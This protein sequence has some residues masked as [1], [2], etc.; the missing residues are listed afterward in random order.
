MV[1]IRVL[2]SFVVLF[3]THEYLCAMCGVACL[4]GMCAGVF[5]NAT[6]RVFVESWMGAMVGVVYWSERK[7][8]ESFN[9]GMQVG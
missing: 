6:Q 8:E 3:V 7:R 9:V 1:R 2:V 4:H 5:K